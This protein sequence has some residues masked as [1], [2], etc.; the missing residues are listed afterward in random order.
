M[1]YVIRSQSLVNYVVTYI[2][3]KRLKHKYS[4]QQEKGRYQSLIVDDNNRKKNWQKKWKNRFLTLLFFFES[5]NHIFIFSWLD[6]FKDNP[7][8]KSN[9]HYHNYKERPSIRIIS[10]GI[11]IF[12]LFWCWDLWSAPWVLSGMG[13]AMYWL[14]VRLNPD[15]WFLLS[16]NNFCKGFN[17]F[18]R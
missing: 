12:H 1:D 9:Q 3:M 18:D 17:L 16:P 6:H 7:S 11:K 15:R 8:S 10:Y 2:I 5:R 14:N 13:T 4:L